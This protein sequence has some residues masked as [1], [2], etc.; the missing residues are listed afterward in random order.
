[1]AGI[2]NNETQSLEHNR[3]EEREGGGKKK[4]AGNSIIEA[5]NK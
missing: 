5:Q 1:M 3:S 2:P 4:T